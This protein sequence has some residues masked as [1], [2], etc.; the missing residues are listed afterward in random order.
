MLRGPWGDVLVAPKGG[1]NVVAGRVV[2]SIV[3]PGG[4]KTAERRRSRMSLSL[5]PNQSTAKGTLPLSPYSV[6]L[7]IT[8]LPSPPRK[9]LFP[10]SSL[11]VLNR[12]VDLQRSRKRRC[13]LS[14]NAVAREAVVCRVN[15][16]K[17]DGM[18]LPTDSL[19]GRDRR[20]VLQRS[21]KRVRPLIPNVVAPEAARYR[22]LAVSLKPVPLCRAL[23][24]ASS[25]HRLTEGT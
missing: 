14:P 17:A 2:E 23:D 10:E 19:K 24:A 21:R 11:K 20:V 13:T 12:L 9:R 8:N 22:G 4:R 3:E 5:P 16:L 1:L 25:P 7:S 15:K 18:G 6:T